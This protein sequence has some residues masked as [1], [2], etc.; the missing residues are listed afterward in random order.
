MGINNALKDQ[1][2]LNALIMA[3]KMNEANHIRQVIETIPVCDV[4]LIVSS[5]GLQFIKRLLYI[6][7]SALD[8]SKHVQFYLK[9]LKHIM[10]IHGS[11]LVQQGNKPALVA[12]LQSVERRNEQLSKMCDYNQYMTDYVRYSQKTVVKTLDEDHDEMNGKSDLDSEDEDAFM[13]NS[14]LD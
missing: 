10:T 8:A 9:W 4:E 5:L 12:V 2:Y 7:A 1:D 13:D 11:S 14:V 6:F 3:V